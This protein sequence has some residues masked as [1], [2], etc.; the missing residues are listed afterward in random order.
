MK[1]TR[2]LEKDQDQ[3]RKDEY[4]VKPGR[5]I[6]TRRGAQ[7]LVFLKSRWKS[8]TWEHWKME[9]D[10]ARSKDLSQKDKKTVSWQCWVGEIILEREDECLTRIV[11]MIGTGLTCEPN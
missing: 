7:D 4:R 5:R 8:L 11:M 6:Q 3:K 10:S 9:I 1:K 2:G